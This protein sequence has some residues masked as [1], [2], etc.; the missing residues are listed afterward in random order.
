MSDKEIFY[1]I[2]FREI[3]NLLANFKNPLVNV[4][5]DPVKRY[6]QTFLEPYV[7]AFIEPPNNEINSE[8]A[9]EFLKEESK[10]KIDA[11]KKRFEKMRE[12]NKNNGN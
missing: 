11:F 12:I 8:M 7:E 9:S 3:D 6:I 10:E 4:F 5:S 1:Q 2:L